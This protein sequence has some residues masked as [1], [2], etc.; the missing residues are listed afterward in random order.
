[1]RRPSSGPT[2][3]RQGLVAPALLLAGLLACAGKPAD[4]LA[5]NMPVRQLV[6]VSVDGLR[7]DAIG[8]A[9]APQLQRLLRHS[10]WSL[11]ARTVGK[12]DTLP[13]H[14]SMVSGRSPESHGVNW[15]KNRGG[16]LEGPSLFTRVQ[17]AGGSTFMLFGKSKLL[18]LAGAR[19]ADLVQGPGEGESNWNSGAD[20]ALAARFAAE[21]ATRKPQLAMVHLREPD[22]IG[23]KKGWMSADYLDAVRVADAALGTV[24]AAIDAS[25]L[26]D[27][28][29]VL[30]TADHG[31]EGDEHRSGSR[32]SETIPWLCR[33]PGIKP[34]P[35]RG[36]VATVDIAP[37]ALALLG[38]PPLAGIEGKVVQEC[39]PIPQAQGKP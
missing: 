23:H 1:M 13:S 26:A 28:T 5:A 38:L 10:A 9:P 32:L 17:D 25:G 21:F 11:Q 22:H 36:P 19:G 37:T 3:L 34:Q 8:A 24:L 29:A 33:V 4:G 15:N 31:G 6:L 35:I 30:L 12:P 2:A 16:Q 39:L 14:V 27:S 18:F 20:A 7:P